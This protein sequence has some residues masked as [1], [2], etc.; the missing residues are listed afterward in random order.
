MLSNIVSDKNLVTIRSLKVVQSY[1]CIL[2][3]STK[4]EKERNLKKRWSQSVLGDLEASCYE[5]LADGKVQSCE[6]L[7]KLV[8]VLIVDSLQQQQALSH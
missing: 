1:A 2:E 6:G 3:S 8:M 5:K 4:G 7:E